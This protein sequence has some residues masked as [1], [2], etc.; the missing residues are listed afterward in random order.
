MTADCEPAPVGGAL[1]P[2]TA[3]GTVLVVRVSAAVPGAC[4]SD[5]SIGTACVARGD[6]VYV[7]Q[8][9]AGSPVVFAYGDGDQVVVSG[10][11]GAG[12]SVAI[13]SG[14]TVEQS[15]A[16]ARRCS[17]L[18]TNRAVAHGPPDRPA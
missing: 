14:L 2:G 4:V 5:T 16:V 12:D 10:W 11:P 7:A 6:D 3:P 17:A 9:T 1:L 13:P 18:A 8:M 15:A